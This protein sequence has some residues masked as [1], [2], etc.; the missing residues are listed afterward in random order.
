M[1]DAMEDT[2]MDKDA[3]N[4]SGSGNGHDSSGPETETELLDRRVYCYGCLAPKDARPVVDQMYLAHRYRIELSLIE[5]GRRAAVRALLPEDRKLWAAE[6]R[7]R[8]AEIAVI[9]ERAADLRRGAREIASQTWGLYWG[10]YQLVEEAEQASRRSTPLYEDTRWPPW[11]GEGSVSVQI[12]KGMSSSELAQDTQTQVEYVPDAKR[13]EEFGTLRLR[14]GS[15]GRRPIW[16]EWP[17]RLHRPLPSGCSIKRVTV[18]RRLGG[19]RTSNPRS[20]RRERWE[21]QFILEMRLG[22]PS[23]GSG[24]VGVDL[25]WR[26]IGEELRVCA[27]AD[28]QGRTGELR[29]S[30]RLIGG[31]RRVESLRKIRD[32]M[33]NHALALVVGLRGEADVP[34]WFKKATEHAHAWCNPKRIP[35]LLRDWQVTESGEAWPMGALAF[36]WLSYWLERDRHLWQWESDQSRK[37]Q[38][39]KRKVY[40]NFASSLAKQYETIVLEELDLRVFAIKPSKDAL[41]G[42]D[43][44]KE[45]QQEEKARA[46]RHLAGTYQLRLALENAALVRG[47][48]VCR[49]PAVNT[50]RTCSVCGLVVR[51]DFGGSVAWTCDC[52]V[53]HDQDKNAGTNLCERF[54]ALEEAG[55]ARV[56]KAGKAKGEMKSRFVRAK[57]KK[58]QRVA[59]AK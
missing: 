5:R 47:G 1:I 13:G 22:A 4:V 17:V 28:E 51:R 20:G 3:G 43:G 31:Y 53:V 57:E 38:N 8:A 36:A 46:W 40:E 32:D 2:V 14:I 10:T 56:R 25:G 58:A 34:P 41:V 15:A 54:R 27:F 52:G 7:S 50:T 45:S 21:V 59:L 55:T 18:H 12:M 23:C 11:K 6:L 24:V 19:A 35:M 16:A 42:P 29:L 37:N 33:R 26:R 39:C 44:R 30:A 49:V 48:S 9:D